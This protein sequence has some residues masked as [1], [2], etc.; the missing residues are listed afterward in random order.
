V[1]FDGTHAE[2]FITWGNGTAQDDQ[3][4]N[5]RVGVRVGGG[6]LVGVGTKQN[7]IDELIAIE[8]AEGVAE[9][10]PEGVRLRDGWSGRD[11][12]VAGF[13]GFVEIWPLWYR[14]LIQLG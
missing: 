11:I 2:N 7:Q 12:V 5:V 6:G 9:I 3:D 10:L 13:K 4:I 14:L 1:D 8:L